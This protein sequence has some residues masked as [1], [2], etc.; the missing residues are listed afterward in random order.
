MARGH[1]SQRV[2][3]VIRFRPA[4]HTLYWIGYVQGRTM[5]IIGIPFGP[6]YFT[7]NQSLMTCLL[8]E[9]TGFSKEVMR[10]TPE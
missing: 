7:R 8:C 9:S 4:Q 5:A 1:S 3:N 2:V 10:L 6:Q